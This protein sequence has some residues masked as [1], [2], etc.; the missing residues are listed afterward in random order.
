MNDN[1]SYKHISSEISGHMVPCIQAAG[2][3]C[4]NDSYVIKRKKYDSILIIFTIEGKGYLKYRNKKHEI[5]KG[6]GFIIDCNEP[7]VYFTGEDGMWKFLWVHYKGGQSINQVKYIL[8]NNGPI[9]QDVING[10]ID[11]KLLNILDIVANKGVYFDIV[12]SG[13]LNEIIHHLMLKTIHHDSNDNFIPDIVANAM[14]IIE[15]HYADNISLESLAKELYVNK[16][17]LI[18]VFKKYMGI[19]PYDYLIKY[20]INQAKTL[21][22][23]T[24]LPVSDI[25]YKV[26]FMDS[27]YFIKVFK[28]HEQTTPLRY[29]RYWSST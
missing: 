11:K 4:C 14:D 22:E 10:L 28:Q 19:T 2:K 13:Y 18:R 12:M 6:N 25:A 9:F 17:N 29:R 20:R 26:G 16:Y 3:Y 15:S 24:S 7:H 8:D 27:S 23:T 5:T 1:I 21:L